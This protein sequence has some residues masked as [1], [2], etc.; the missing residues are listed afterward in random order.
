VKWGGFP[1]GD[2]YGE[3]AA[4]GEETGIGFQPEKMGK[5]QAAEKFQSAAVAASDIQYGG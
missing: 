5:A 3:G 2:G 1:S 4:F